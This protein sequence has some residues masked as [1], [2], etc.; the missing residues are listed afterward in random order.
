MRHGVQAAQ[1]VSRMCLVCGVENGGGL[2][3]RF[4]VLENGELAGVFRPREEH[5]SYPGRL[6]GGVVSAILDE[7]IGRAIN[8]ADTQTWGVTV[9]F[10]VRFRQPVPMDR[11]VK[12]VGRIT[13][14]SRRIFEGTGEI[15]LEDGT[16]AA[17]AQG[18]YLKL[19]IEDIA[20]VEFSESEWFAD[21]LPLPAEI[22]LGGEA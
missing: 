22:D 20:A 15:V 3:G 12:A 2:Q 7:T 10:T 5:Q 14:D 19:P 18:K 1:N 8:V 9:E 21:E 17:E 16:I 6:H 13:R 4:F 11:E